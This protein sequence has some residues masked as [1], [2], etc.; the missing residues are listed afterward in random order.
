MQKFIAS[1]DDFGDF[2]SG[3]VRGF[4]QEEMDFGQEFG[5]GSPSVQK[6]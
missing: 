6:K 1:Q 3:D 4:G 2:N 5:F